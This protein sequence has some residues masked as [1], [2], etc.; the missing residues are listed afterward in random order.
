MKKLFTSL[1]FLFVTGTALAQLNI[2]FDVST[3]NGENISCF[4]GNDGWVTAN[5]T[6]GTPP[7]T[8]LWSNGATTQTISN[9]PASYYA[10]TV[11]D[12]IGASLENG[13]NLREPQQITVE[14]TS[15][16][17]P[18]GFNVSCY[19]C[20]NGSI[21]NTTSAGVSPYSFSWLDGPTTQN[22]TSVGGGIYKVTVT[23]ANSC[24]LLQ[25]ITLREPERNDWTI[26][27]NSG[28]NPAV[29]YIGTA[30]NT[31]LL[32]KSNA[33]ERIR[34]LSNG[35]IRLTPFANPNDNSG[36][37]YA[38]MI[39]AA[40]NL[41]VNGPPAY[42]PEPTFGCPWS[43]DFWH[44]NGCDIVTLDNVGI[45]TYIVPYDYKLAV[46]GKIIA[47]EVKVK[48]H[49]TW[50]P[51]FVFERDYKLMSLKDLEKYL[52]QF[53]HLPEIPSAA[54]MKNEDGIAVGDFQMKLLQKIEELTLYIIDLQ[55][56]INELKK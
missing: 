41:V 9:L 31:D 42:M 4:G 52:E 27:G 19:Q 11:T 30:D 12:N 17:Y 28:S 24:T 18:N 10:V 50:P 25:S 13:L 32:L 33:A 34:L 53:K 37:L 44:Y 29:H 39:D 55:K 43:T 40:G 45:G 49:G 16:L 14:L 21:A 38:V 48:L 56:Q 35:T 20:F 46:K 23:D 7:Y 54:E 2:S 47:E 22:R 8:Y 36:R 51:D 3:Y 6:G 5:V 26:T 1:S 15:P